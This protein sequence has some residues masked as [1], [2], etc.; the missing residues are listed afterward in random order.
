MQL[1]GQL[2]QSVKG[3][4]RNLN[5]HLVLAARTSIMKFAFIF[6]L[7]LAL[8]FV[9]K[10]FEEEKFIEDEEENYARH[11]LFRKVSPFPLNALVLPFH[12]KIPIVFRAQKLF[13][14]HNIL[15]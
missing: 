5:L 8:V 11:H 3:L 7:C 13:Y 12:S 14:V 1:R 6:G 15:E 10:S 9:V 4:P 2:L